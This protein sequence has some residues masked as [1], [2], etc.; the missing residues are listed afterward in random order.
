[1]LDNRPSVGFEDVRK[2][3]VP[4]LN[5]RILLNYK[6]KFEGVTTSDVLSDLTN[7]IKETDLGLESEIEI[8]AA[9]S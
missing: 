2:V 6:A 3:V 8:Q 5:H 9:G 1:L 7:R 4:A